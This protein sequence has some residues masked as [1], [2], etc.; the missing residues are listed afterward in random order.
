MTRT[1]QM[2]FRNSEGRNVTVSVPDARADLQ[3][4][5]VETEMSEIIGRNIFQTSGGDILEAVKAQVVS[6]QVEILVEF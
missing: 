5:E 6:R 1:L 3:P 2:I 4:A